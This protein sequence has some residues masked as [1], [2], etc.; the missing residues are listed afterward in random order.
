MTPDQINSGFGLAAGL[1]LML[2]VK[3]LYHD[4][5]LRGVCIAPTAFMAAWGLWNLY[6]YPYIGAWWSF[7]TGLLIV[8]VNVIWVGQMFYYK[9]KGPPWRNYTSKYTNVDK[10]ELIRKMRKAM[11]NT[12]FLKPLEYSDGD[13][14]N[15]CRCPHESKETIFCNGFTRCEDCPGTHE[16]G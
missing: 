3:K 11:Q 4:K 2:N 6:F 1:L 8:A 7:T 13:D 15:C 10:E 14:P 9:W 12:T 5:Q 16:A